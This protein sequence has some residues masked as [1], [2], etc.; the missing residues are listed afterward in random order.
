MAASIGTAPIRGKT[1]RRV[2]PALAAVPVAIAALMLA[3]CPS[4]TRETSS[5]RPSILL[6]TI[7]S[8]RADRVGYAG[9]AQGATP[10]LDTLASHSIRFTQAQTPA[11]LTTPALASLLTGR[12]PSH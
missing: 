6:V 9:Y 7:D 1:R 3:G 5:S 8:L 2:P 10:N 4:G 12:Y 11:P